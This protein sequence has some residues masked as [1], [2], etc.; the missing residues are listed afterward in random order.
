MTTNDDFDD[1]PR[2][3]GEN[4]LRDQTKK[5]YDHLIKNGL[6]HSLKYVKERMVALGFKIGRATCGRHLEDHPVYI[7]EQLG[8]TKGRK[9][10]DAE[11]RSMRRK[12]NNRHEHKVG[13]EKPENVAQAAD[14]VDPE[15][16]GTIANR[17]IELLK[18]G[19]DNRPV[20]SSAELAIE[21]N[22]VAMALNIVIAEAMAAKS[23]LLLLDMRG[24]AALIDALTIARKLSGGASID[25]SRPS[26]SEPPHHLNGSNGHANGHSPAG[27]LMKEINPPEKGL[28]ADIAAFRRER[29]AKSAQRA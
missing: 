28:S 1:L 14:A 6:P 17:I 21:E 12:L 10:N 24:T 25:I 8:G 11:K 9:L 16:I 22:R 3:N 7:A 18:V 26:G 27:F 5:V 15:K 29:A 19:V 20:K 23:E 2:G 4:P 13:A